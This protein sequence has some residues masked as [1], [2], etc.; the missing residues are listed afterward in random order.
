M[1]AALFKGWGLSCTREALAGLS[2][3]IRLAPLRAS[4]DKCCRPLPVLT[5]NQNFSTEAKSVR[6]SSRCP[7]VVA[8]LAQTPSAGPSRRA[9]CPV[10]PGSSG[11]CLQCARSLEF[12]RSIS[13]HHICVSHAERYDDCLQRLLR[14]RQEKD[15]AGTILGDL[16]HCGPSFGRH[17]STNAVLVA[18]DQSFEAAKQ[19]L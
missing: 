6:T 13:A 7:S 18:G 19:N 14:K 2:A 10:T 12:S 11:V 1:N 4:S 17:L 15:K 8:A 3:Y 9:R 16:A 5:R